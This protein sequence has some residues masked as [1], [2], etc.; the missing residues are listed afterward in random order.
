MKPIVFHRKAEAEML[1]A[2]GHYEKKRPALGLECLTE[3]EDATRRIQHNP[4]GYPPFGRK[5]IRFCLVRRFPY[6]L[7]YRETDYYIR[8]F[9]VSHGRRRP[10]YWSRRLK[11]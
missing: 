7:Y 3:V 1:I 8:V 11:P 4:K 5:G 9:A 6:L 2:A 10:G